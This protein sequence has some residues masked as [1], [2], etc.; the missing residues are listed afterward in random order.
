LCSSSLVPPPPPLPRHLKSFPTTCIQELRL[1]TPGPA[2][3][4]RKRTTME[5]VV[6]FPPILLSNPHSRHVNPHSRQ[7]R[8]RRQRSAY[9]RRRSLLQRDA[10]E[11]RDENEQ[12][13]EEECGPNP[14]RRDGVGRVRPN[15][16]RRGGGGGM[17]PSPTR[18]GV[19]G[20]MQPNPTRRGRRARS[21]ALLPFDEQEARPRKAQ[22]APT[23]MRTVQRRSIRPN[24]DA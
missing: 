10:A 7:R 20:G 15:P 19:G 3:A 11:V 22:P 12:G 4:Y 14:T 18:R 23:T 9:R 1:Q 8:Q 21:A 24:D 2:S 13:S 6:R 5:I 17:G 16:T